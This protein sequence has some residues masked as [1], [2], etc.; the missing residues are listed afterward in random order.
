[1]TDFDFDTLHAHVES[2]DQELNNLKGARY[3]EEG[4]SPQCKVCNHPEVDEIERLREEG[5][6][7]EK[8]ISELDLDMSIMSLSRHFNNHYTKKTAYFLKRKKLMLE[9]VIETIKKYPYLETYFKNRDDE[10]VEDFIEY[11]GFCTDC[12]E[13]C[14]L[15]LPATVGNSEIVQRAYNV[16]IHSNLEKSLFGEPSTETM[17]LVMRKMDCLKCKNEILT[18]RL[19]IHEK[20]L[21]SLLNIDDVAPN[22][23]LYKLNIDYDDDLE[24]FYKHLLI[25]D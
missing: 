7:Y 5:Y 16:K 2:L 14:D 8:L 25:T 17:E 20:L 19:N 3:K 4:Y 10:D 1:M 9:N 24:E 12:F 22:E 15:I 11:C 13:L 18:K 21:C 23:L 6:T